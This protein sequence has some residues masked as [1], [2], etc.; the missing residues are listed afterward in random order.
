MD[1]EDN[2]HVCVGGMGL[3]KVT[4]EREVILLTDETNR[5][6][7]SILDDSRLRMP[8]DLDIAPDGRIFFSDATV[9][10]SNTE[11]PVDSIEART[12]GRLILYDPHTKKTRT[13]LRNL[14]FSNG[15]CV[16]LDGE[17][18]LVAETWGCRVTRYWFD[19][20]NKGRTEVVLDNLPG[21]PDNINRASDGNYWCAIVGMRGRAFDHMLR[22]PGVRARMTRRLGNDEWLFPNLND[23]CVIKFDLQGTVMESLW[24]PTGISH[25]YITSMREHKGKLYLGG[26]SNN[27]IGVHELSG[28]DMGWTSQFSYWGKK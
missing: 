13:V 15:V 11:W 27:R 22:F 28:V 2:I 21:Y 14:R 20:P 19:G 10:F 25:P 6:L 9:R 16:T 12:N 8:D 17:S 24:D 1:A 4:P 3:Y 7:T 23:G 26:I 5:S 18:L